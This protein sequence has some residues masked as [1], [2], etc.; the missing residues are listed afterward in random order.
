MAPFESGD[1]LKYGE[2]HPVERVS[3]ERRSE[4][5]QSDRDEIRQL[6][7]VEGAG[8]SCPIGG[9]LQVSAQ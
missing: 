1:V 7:V 6:L 5:L 4:F 9:N 8:F 3:C 2:H